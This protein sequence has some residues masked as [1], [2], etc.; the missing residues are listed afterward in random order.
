M[1]AP[2]AVASA[3]GLTR[4]HL[5]V[6]STDNAKGVGLATDGWLLI[7]DLDGTALG[8]H[9][10]YAQFPPEFG[11]FLDAW[12][13]DGN[14]WATN[15]TWGL[16]AQRLLILGSRVTSLPV[17]VCGESGRRIG[18][19][20]DGTVVLDPVHEATVQAADHAFREKMWPIVRPLMAGLLADDL[21]R[22]AAYD[23]Y[24]GQYMIDLDCQDDCAGEVWRRLEPLLASGDYYTWSPQHGTTI[25]LLPRHMNKGEAVRALQQRLEIGPERTILAGDG[26][27]DLPMLSRSLAH[28]LVCPANAEPQVKARVEELGGIVAEQDYSWG[29]VEGVRSILDGR[30]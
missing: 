9:D 14:L 22:R 21:V 26:T 16:E 7:F 1:A 6:W 8:G 18:R 4:T 5:G 24:R 15:T 17:F 30:A 27:N 25:C 11:A 2:P 19:L 29:V 28:W 10:P 23:Y 3:G 12:S 20:V 13:T